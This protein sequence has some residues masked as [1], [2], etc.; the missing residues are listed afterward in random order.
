MYN[1]LKIFCCLSSPSVAKNNLRKDIIIG[2]IRLY[3]SN[4]GKQLPNDAKFC[5]NCGTTL[6]PSKV[7]YKDINIPINLV[8]S[9]WA[10]EIPQSKR[11]EFESIILE[12]IKEEGKQGWQPFHPCDYDYLLQTDKLIQTTPIFL[13]VGSFKLKSANIRLRRNY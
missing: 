7:E 6:S 8:W 12:R 13:G 2:V 11:R 3:C 9:G 10:N 5:P 1:L 4:C